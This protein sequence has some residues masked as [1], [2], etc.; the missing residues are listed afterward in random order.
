MPLECMDARYIRDSVLNLSECSHLEPQL[1]D[2]MIAHVIAEKET[3]QLSLL[4]VLLNYI[5]FFGYT[6]KN[7]DEFIDAVKKMTLR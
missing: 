7:C 4:N 3:L 2:T 5:F 6:P 1:T